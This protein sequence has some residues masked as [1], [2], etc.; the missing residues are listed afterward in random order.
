MTTT[1]AGT[2]ASFPGFAPFE[3]EPS[4][5]SAR[6]RKPSAPELRLAAW[7]AKVDR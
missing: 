4:P 1:S 7:L 6:E 2:E 5:E 3:P